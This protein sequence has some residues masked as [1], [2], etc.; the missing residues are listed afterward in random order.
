MRDN[1]EN[2][3][4]IPVYKTGKWTDDVTYL[5]CKT[6]IKN[7]KLPAKVGFDD[8]EMCVV[9]PFEINLN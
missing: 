8:S 3:I 2:T 1:M 5:I 4:A 9:V 6:R 7:I